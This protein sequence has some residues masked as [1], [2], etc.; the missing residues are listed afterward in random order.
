MTG[1]GLLFVGF[2]A[3]AF[4]SN[5]Y[6]LAITLALTGFGLS[7]AYLPQVMLLMV[8]FPERFPFMFGL[9][10]LGGSFGMMVCP[11]IVDLLTM[12]YGWRGAMLIIAAASLNVTACGALQ[13]LP[14]SGYAKLKKEDS[15]S[16]HNGP[17]DIRSK[18]SAFA[19]SVVQWLSLHFCVKHPRVLLHLTTWPLLGAVFA[20]WMVFLVPHAIAR[21][22][23][24]VQAAFL[25]TAGG[26]GHLLGRAVH[27]FILD[28]K[29]MSAFW[30]FVVLNLV[31]TVSFFLD[32]AAA[33]NYLALMLLAGVNGAAEGVINWI[34][35]SVTKELYEET[36]YVTDIYII[37]I[38][39]F[40]TGEVLG[41]FLAGELYN[42]T[43]NYSASFFSLGFMAGVTT[44]MCIVD[45]LASKCFTDTG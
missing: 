8:S 33:D 30:M 4:V 44:A 27:P 10:G 24:S 21:G 15:E 11:P 5:V 35:L 41:S 20:A 34:A 19:S 2:L 14:P 1:G 32:Y 25:S 3:T 22:I 29:L 12:T 39:L 16:S 38:C 7:L 45:R 26:I 43:Q 37:G 9:A 31:N 42:L 17:S 28:R 6:Q 40:G 18:L 13:R 23:P 36:G